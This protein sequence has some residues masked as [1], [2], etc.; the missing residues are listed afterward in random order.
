M[1]LPIPEWWERYGRRERLKSEVRSFYKSACLGKRRHETEAA[2]ADHANDLAVNFPDFERR[3]PYRCPFC[4]GWHV[5]RRPQSS[6]M[7]RRDEAVLRFARM[8]LVRQIWL[9]MTARQYGKRMSLKTNSMDAF[10]HI[11]ETA[12][13]ARANPA[14]TPAE[15]GAGG[16]G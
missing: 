4:G 2:A 8:M 5:G 13:Q 14:N 10:R 11:V 7:D 3:H 1:N 9:L 15:P 12:R 6:S 16:R